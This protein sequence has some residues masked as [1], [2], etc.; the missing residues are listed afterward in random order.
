MIGTVAGAVA[1]LVLTACF[2]QDRVA[3][4]AGLALG[5]SGCAFVATIL[6]NFS[7]LAAQLA[8]ITAAIIASSQLGATGGA[9]G[10]A[11]MLAVVRC[12]EICVGI[13]SAGVVLAGT[14]FGSA[15]R[16]AGHPVRGHLDRGYAAVCLYLG[17]GWPGTSGD[18]ANAAGADSAGR[19][20]R[21]NHRRGDSRSLSA[22]PS[23]SGV[24]DGGMRPSRSGGQLARRGGSL[25]PA[26]T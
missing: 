26:A 4:L 9:N 10:E 23:F 19:R 22:A 18:A 16:P 5:G 17:A 15:S 6:R 11:F 8:G 2:P 12:T 20:A 21:P 24:G 14:D 3:F 1:I 13:V 7:A 25:R